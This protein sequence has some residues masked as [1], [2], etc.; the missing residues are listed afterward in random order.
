[1]SLKKFLKTMQV[2]H[3]NGRPGR[4]ASSFLAGACTCAGFLLKVSARMTRNNRAQVM[5]EYFIILCVVT[6]FAMVLNSSSFFGRFRTNLNASMKSAMETMDQP[7][8]GS[9]TSGTS[10]AGTGDLI[11]WWEEDINDTDAT[12]W[13][14]L[15]W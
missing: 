9:G 2:M 13:W 6:L 4:L 7:G 8:V 3:P 15:N 1:M 12:P 14:V 5:M 10:G 11:P